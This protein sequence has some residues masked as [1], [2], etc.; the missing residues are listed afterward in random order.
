MVRL[1]DAYRFGTIVVNGKRYTSDVLI[2]PEKVM[3]D[4]RRR[5]GHRLHVDDLKEV[6]NAE[7]KPESLIVGTGYFGL[8][9]VLSEV[10]ESLRTRRI[11]FVA[12]RTKQA[13]Q[14]FN[15]LL[16]SRRRAV[17]ALHLAC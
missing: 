1:I 6:L 10:E 14:T 16:K 17:A 3:D 12:Q 4:W 8:M 15:D 7:P 9:K 13:C 5:E 2:L 11:G